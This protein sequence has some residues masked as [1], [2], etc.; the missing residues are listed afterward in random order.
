MLRQTEPG[1][2]KLIHCNRLGLLQQLQCLTF[3]RLKVQ[4]QACAPAL[5][6]LMVSA[7]RWPL[8]EPPSVASLQ[9]SDAEGGG[10][11]SEVNTADK[12]R[13]LQGEVRFPRA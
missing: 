5:S 1:C 11:D 9:V 2:V 4:T 12:S 7:W 3:S 10:K 13:A 6:V 8:P